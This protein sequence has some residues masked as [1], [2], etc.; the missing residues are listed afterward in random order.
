[1]GLR[2]NEVGKVLRVSSGGFDMS[3]FTELEIV[4]KLPDETEVIKATAD[5]VIIGPGVTDPD[6]GVLLVNEYVEY[7]TEAG[8]L[9]QA[10]EW[11]AYIRYTNTT[12][13]PNHIYN[14]DC[15][16]FTV[17]DVC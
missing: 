13:T 16:T 7:P 2:V 5:G 1:M 8:F 17:D 9:S 12:P 4:F 11:Q 3:T 15:V 6:L 14:G 10:G